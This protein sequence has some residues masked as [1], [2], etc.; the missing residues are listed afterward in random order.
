MLYG[1]MQPYINAFVGTNFCNESQTM[2]EYST[3]GSMDSSSIHIILNYSF[4]FNAC[5]LCSVTMIW[6]GW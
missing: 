4:E 6:S 5:P 3:E 1:F 2:H